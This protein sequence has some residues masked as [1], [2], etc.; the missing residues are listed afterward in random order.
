MRL[1]AAL[2]VVPVCL[3]AQQPTRIALDA[4]SGELQ[5]SF[6]QITAVRELRDGR[7]LVVDV[8][9]GRVVVG[10]FH[11]KQV[12]AVGRQGQGPLEYMRPWHLV[13]LPE[14]RTLVQDPGNAR[15]LEVDGDARLTGELEL[16]APKATRFSLPS[17][18]ISPQA[19]GSDAMGRLYFEP[20]P[21]EAGT[22]LNALVVRLDLRAGSIDTVA[23]YSMPRRTGD[24]SVSS[25]RSQEFVVR[26]NV[27][28]PRSQWAVAPDGRIALVE[29]AP[30]R[31]SW[32]TDGKRVDGP[33]Q[34]Y[35][36]IRVIAEDREAY[37]ESIGRPAG[38]AGAAPSGTPVKREGEPVF[39][40]TMPPFIGKE[41]LLIAP[42]GHLWIART[43][44][45][46]DPV[47]RYDV[48][49]NNGRLAGRVE[50]PDRRRVVAF[51]SRDIYVAFRDADDLEH[52]ERYRR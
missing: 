21:R 42:D 49:D 6:T 30:Y 31:V 14:G 15:F 46:K 10:D 13:A 11:T 29:P 18:S 25:P 34:S 41:A 38:N 9:D 52:L 50:L 2:L 17:R 40:E 35:D 28:N 43:K 4:R 44:H 51:G 33:A 3:P 12:S 32:I 37:L 7:V 26:V 27:W 47:H 23:R 36:P 16:E 20:Y 45:A 8:R 24:Y 1:V 22:T 5:E 19:W 39:P 48:F